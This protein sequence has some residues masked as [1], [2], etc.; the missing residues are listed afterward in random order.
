MDDFFFGVDLFF[1]VDGFFGGFA[2]RV[3]TLAGD[4]VADG[5]ALTGDCGG[6]FSLMDLARSVAF[7]RAASSAYLN[8]S[9]PPSS[10]VFFTSAA[11]FSRFGLI[12]IT[13]VSPLPL[14]TFAAHSTTPFGPEVRRSHCVSS[15]SR[16][17]RYD[18][19]KCR[20]APAALHCGSDATP[21]SR[22]SRSKYSGERS[23]LV[24]QMT[25][26]ARWKSCTV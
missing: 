16:Q 10:F 25:T 26:S 17:S 3:L 24:A 13:D 23:T 18:A 20:P 12:V 15:L 21:A 14:R 4:F 2:T 19:A 1:G 11:P 6:V 5:F 22:A 7:F 9:I 8:P